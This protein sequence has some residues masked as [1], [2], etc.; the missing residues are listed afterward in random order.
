MEVGHRCRELVNVESVTVREEEEWRALLYYD[1][2]DFLLLQ[3]PDASLPAWR[4]TVSLKNQVPQLR[5][6]F[7]IFFGPRPLLICLVVEFEVARGST[8]RA[9]SDRN[10]GEVTRAVT[11][12]G[13]GERVAQGGGVGERDREA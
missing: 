3:K 10:T 11:L 6:Y 13:R 5:C 8:N 1:I 2:L 4:S 7:N 9:R 12:D